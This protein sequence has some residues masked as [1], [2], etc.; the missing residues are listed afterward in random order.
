MFESRAGQGICLK[1][2][3][4]ECRKHFNPRVMSHR[5]SHVHN[6]G[7]ETDGIRESSSKALLCVISRSSGGK[8]PACNAGDP[9]KIPWRRNR[10]PTPVFLGFLG[11]SAA[12]ETACNVGDLG[13]IPG[14]GRSPGEGKGYPL[15]CSGLKNSMD[16][17]VHR[18][19]KSWTELSDFRFSSV[20]GPQKFIRVKMNIPLSSWGI[21]WAAS[22]PGLFEGVGAASTCCQGD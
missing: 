2:L 10:Q 18:V 11:G 21:F 5:T 3:I 13:S 22:P 4:A 7:L 12:K 8:E 1:I 20:R 14:L 19:E 6:E 15:Q 16:G 17:I 9:G